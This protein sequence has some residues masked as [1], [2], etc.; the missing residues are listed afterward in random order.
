MKCTIALYDL[1]ENVVGQL[2][3]DGTLEV[4]DE[5]MAHWVAPHFES[6]TLCKSCYVLPGCQGAACPLTRV[7]SGHR[8]CCGVKQNLKHEMRF[9]LRP[10]A[11]PERELAEMA[12]AD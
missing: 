11:R 6:D 12:A 5:Q 10:T 7:K 3:P 8:T 1:E 4:Q 2:H 9:T